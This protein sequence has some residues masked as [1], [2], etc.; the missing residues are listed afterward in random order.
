MDELIIS[1]L[2]KLKVDHRDCSEVTLSFKPGKLPEVV[3]TKI[4]KDD[5]DEL[6]ILNDEIAKVSDRYK[7]VED[8][9]GGS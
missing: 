8:R 9:H 4:L 6:I 1:I 2:D 5:S 3:I 7:L